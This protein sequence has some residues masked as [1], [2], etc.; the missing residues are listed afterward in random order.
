MDKT[1]EVGLGERKTF[2]H[3]KGEGESSTRFFQ[4]II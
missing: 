1:C 3:E 4:V 2:I